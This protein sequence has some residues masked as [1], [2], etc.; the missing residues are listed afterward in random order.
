MCWHYSGST[1]KSAAETH[2][3]MTFLDNDSYN[4]DDACIFNI[5]CK[6]RLIEKYLMDAS[7]PFHTDNGWWESSVKIRLPKEKRKCISEADAPQLKIEGVHHQS[8]TSI[9]TSV[10]EDSVLSTFHMTLFQQ[11]W[12]TSDR[13]NI[14][15]FSEAYSSI[16]MREAY[17]E[18]NSLPHAADDNLEHI[19][20]SLMMWLDATHLASFGDALLWPFYLFFGNQ[21]KYTRGKPTA[22]AC[23][24]VAY[25]P[26]ICCASLILLLHLL[27]H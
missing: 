10:F 17:S 22:S 13:R 7:N 9:I 5:P 23:H 25:I 26:T 6:R 12:E 24:H 2:H 4:R 16:A 15:I 20:A 21:S 1:S 19:V 3:L 11:M 27:N 8:L 18:I 14:E